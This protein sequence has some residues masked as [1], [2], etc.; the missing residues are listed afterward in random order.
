MWRLPTR[1]RPSEQPVVADSFLLLFGFTSGHLL[2]ETARDALFLARLPA[3]RLPWVYLAIAVVALVL[4]QRSPVTQASRAARQSLTSILRLAAVVALALWATIPLVG[5][6]GY[7]VLYVW[8]GVLA[9]LFVVRFWMLAASTF[10]PSQAK[11]LYPVIGAGAVA[12]GIAGAGLAAALAPLLPAGLLLVAAA[13]VFGMTSLARS[14][15]TGPDV[16]IPGDEALDV[17][18]AVRI[19]LARPYLL[20]VGAVLLL[21]AV[22]FTLVDYVFK[23]AVDQSI[24]PARLDTFFALTYLG[25]NILSLLVQVLA[26]GWLI[27]RLGVNRAMAIVPVLILLASLGVA[28]GLG[29]GM[30][31]AL[32]AIDGGLRNSLHKT[33]AELLFVPLGTHL[34]AR[35]KPV[36]DVIGQRG[37]QA[38]ASL[39]ILALLTVSSSMALFAALAAVS[40]TAWAALSLG[41][42]RHY[43]D[44]FRQALDDEI[45]AARWELPALDLPGLESIVAA[46]SS[47]DEQTVITALDLAAA[48]D[49]SHLVPVLLLRSDSAAVVLRTL[50]LFTTAARPDA[51]DAIRA[52]QGHADMR[53]REAAA[54]ALGAHGTAGDR[55]ADDGHLRQSGDRESATPERTAALIASLA[56]RA[57]RDVARAAL[58]S[59]GAGVLPTLVETLSDASVAHD[60][61][62]QVPGV[63]AAFGTAPAAALLVERLG[64]ESDG[65][66][67]YRILRG[68][69]QL[70]RRQPTL[71][72]D[73]R[74]LRRERDRAL[75]MALRF[76]RLRR[77]LERIDGEDVRVR[78][79]LQ[80]LLRDKQAHALERAFRIYNLESANDDFYRAFR[81]LESRRRDLRSGG[82][83]LLEHLLDPEDAARLLS[84]IDDA[85]GREEGEGTGLEAGPLQPISPD[86][87]EAEEILRELA[88]GGSDS[89]SQL[90]TAYLVALRRTEAS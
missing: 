42:R 66:I 13:V 22:T 19:V 81:G 61:R 49:R 73:R 89:I 43:M 34:R 64:E 71:P 38:V 72:M 52:L 53:V 11:R 76:M 10:T 20:R 62:R 21:G 2:L 59:A 40:A 70:R 75:G 74:V 56:D 48:Y 29:L 44:V 87:P 50:D 12:G 82:R 63:I 24:A 65:M 68:L 67:R 7:Y 90:A 35:V 57:E 3:T 31:V 15:A 17:A 45:A 51:A 39:V 36:I 55:G 69:G 77:R 4:F 60:V 16:E 14:P 6:V 41:L 37:G 85:T 18:G 32:K 26:A 58:V 78:L 47:D 23:S 9:T 30:A 1:V 80:A 25:L 54:R 79:L 8:T 83:E 33:G 86:G 5:T 46:M 88:S 28:G 84:L 27:R